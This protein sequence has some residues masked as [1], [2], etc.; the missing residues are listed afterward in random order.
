M[1]FMFLQLSIFPRNWTPEYWTDLSLWIIYDFSE[2]TYTIIILFKTYYVS[3][4][5]A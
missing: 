5:L 3:N 4:T 2:L 1:K